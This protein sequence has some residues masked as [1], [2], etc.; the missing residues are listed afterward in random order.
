MSA[1]L[2]LISMVACSGK[3]NGGS[4]DTEVA[5]GPCQDGSWGMLPSDQVG[6]TSH[7]SLDG[8][9]D[10]D[11][12]EERPFATLSAAV[13]AAGNGGYK[14]IFVWPGE[15][16]GNV[17]IWSGSYSSENA[18]DG[19]GIYG[20]GTDESVVVADDPSSAALEIQYVDDYSVSGLGVVGGLYGIVSQ[21]PQ[22]ASGV[23]TNVRVT[24]S[25]DVGLF[26]YSGTLHGENV[27]ISDIAGIGA[28]V[29]TGL[30]ELHLVDSSIDHVVTAGVLV[31]TGDAVAE[32]SFDAVTINYVAPKDGDYGMGIQ[33]QGFSSC[34]VT[35]S[36]IENVSHAGIYGHE[37]S[38]EIDNTVIRN[39]SHANGEQADGIVCMQDPDSNYNPANF[40]C[41]VSDV[42][43][44]NTYRAGVIVSGVTA[45]DFT[46]LDITEAGYTQEDLSIFAQDGADMND[47]DSASY[48]LLEEGSELPL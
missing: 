39:V 43:I 18:L 38:L 24:D 35:N 9:E 29:G 46:G 16:E 42:T 6:S 30:A 22:D 33:C 5:A 14:N 32:S 45:K 21:N 2:T 27:Q 48:V 40:Q 25:W 23:L 3:G 8:Y 13:D 34:S 4:D 41:D 1:I 11:G 17:S 12:R 15:H 10:G 36:E 47:V 19:L 31:D 37:S 44:E 28:V 7:V 20:C 26:V